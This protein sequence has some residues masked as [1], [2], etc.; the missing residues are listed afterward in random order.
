MSVRLWLVRHGTTDWSD[1]GRLL[2]WTDVAL[3]VNGRRQARAL[4]EGLSGGVFASVWSS[5]LIRATET[6]NLAAGGATADERLRE[7]NF[8][9]LEGK[10]WDECSPFIQQRLLF[11]DEFA[12]PG[13]ESVCE[14]QIRVLDFT[15][16]LHEGEHLLFTHGGVIRALLRHAGRDARVPPGAVE[17]VVL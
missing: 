2:G 13:G 4:R 3:N 17:Q 14:L 11:F 9:E 12:A 15:A 7:L 8:G 5:D 10:H 6:A 16:G 1:A